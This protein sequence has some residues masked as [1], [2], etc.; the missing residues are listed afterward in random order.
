MWKKTYQT[1]PKQDQPPPN[2]N[3][4]ERQMLDDQ[5]FK[6]CAEKE[7]VGGIILTS[8]YS[9]CRD[10]A[11]D[12]INFYKQNKKLK[13]TIR[14]SHPYETK[15]GKD[16]LEGLKDLDRAGITLEAM[17][18]KS[19]FDVLMTEKSWS[20]SMTVG[21]SLLKKMMN[22]EDWFDKVMELFGLDPNRVRKRDAATRKKLAELLIE[23]ELVDKVK[24]N[25]KF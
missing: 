25:L 16:H 15:E 10:C 3:H 6:L 17:T 11:S 7:E 9:P 12:L 24:E 8:N 13:L 5:T 14:F 4:T 23:E 22:E 19:W 21:K 2:K 18:E 20:D 1:L